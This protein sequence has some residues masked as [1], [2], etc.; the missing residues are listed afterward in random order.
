[1]ANGGALNIAVN[2]QAISVASTKP[3]SGQGVQVAMN[4]GV[5]LAGFNK[6]FRVLFDYRV[7]STVM[8]AF[9]PGIAETEI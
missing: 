6:A 2:A 4:P 1:M 8:D 9:R 7:T 3:S 5:G